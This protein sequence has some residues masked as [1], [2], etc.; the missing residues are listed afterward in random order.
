MDVPTLMLQMVADLARVR[1]DTQQMKSMYDDAM[2]YIENRANA[3][4]TALKG[5]FAGIVAAFSIAAIVG[6]I[7][8]VVSGTAALKQ[9]SEVTGATVEGLAN[10][11]SIAKLSDTDMGLVSGTLVKLAKGM[12]G[13]GDE[14]KGFGFALSKLGLSAKDANGQLKPTDQ[15]LLDI[16]LKFDKFADGPGKTAA[17]MALLGKQGAQLLPLLKDMADQAEIFGSK[18]DEERQRLKDL[19][20]QADEYEKNVKRLSVVKSA[21]WKQIVVESIPAMD[22]FVKALLSAKNESSGLKDKV[23]ELAKDGSLRNWAENV[24]LGVA[25]VVDQFDLF[26]RI[27]QTVGKAIGG[28][29]GVFQGLAEAIIAAGEGMS[30]NWIGASK[31]MASSFLLIKE[32]A[33]GAYKDIETVWSKATF[34]DRL[35]AQLDADRKAREA[36]AAKPQLGGFGDPEEAKKAS[37]AILKQMDLLKQAGALERAIIEAN[38]AVRKNILDGELYDYKAQ[39][40]ARELSER[41][42]IEKDTALRVLMAQENRARLQQELADATRVRDE[43]VKLQS[44]LAGKNAAETASLRAQ[45]MQKVIEQ[46]I[47][48]VKLTGDEKIATDAVTLARQKG[49]DALGLYYQRLADQIRA[50]TRATEDQARAAQD[51]TTAEQLQLSLIGATTVQQQTANTVYEYANKLRDNRIAQDR[52]IDDIE[53]KRINADVGNAQLV[54]LK[55]VNAELVTQRDN[56]L[57][58]IPLIDAQQKQVENLRSAW[59][60]IDSTAF[61]VFESMFNKGEDTW[62]KLA[63]SLKKTMIRALYELTVQKWA[64]QIFANISGS[65]GAGIV[66]GVQQGSGL[67]NTASSL[68][69]GAN[70]AYNWAGSAFPALSGGGSSSLGAG[71]GSFWGA[72]AEGASAAGALGGAAATGGGAASLGAGAGAFYGAGAEVGSAAASAAA[73]GAGAEAG[74][75]A[76][77]AAWVP[78][79]GWIVAIAALAYGIFASSKEPT[80]VRGGL[81]FGGPF[82]DNQSASQSAF[83]SFGFGDAQTQQFSGQVGKVMTDAIASLLDLAAKQLSPE[84]VASVTQTIHETVLKSFEGTFTTEDFIN[85]FG[86]QMAKQLLD[87]ALE[88]VDPYARELVDKFTGPFDQLLAYAGDILTVTGLLKDSSTQFTSLFGEAID[89]KALDGVRKEGESFGA[90]LGRVAQEFQLTNTIAVL[91]GKSQ[92]QVWGAVGLASESARA[93]LISFAGGADKLNASLGSYYDHYFSAE[94]KLQHQHDALADSFTGLGATMPSTLA[95]FRSLIEAQDLKTEAGRKEYAGL[96]ALEGQFY[97]YTTAANAAAGVTDDLAGS[98]GQL[99]DLMKTRSSLEIELMQ[100]QGNAA[101]ALAAQRKLDIA[102]M[103]A[104]EIAAYDYNKALEAQIATQN[105]TND[106]I[107]SGNGISIDLLRAEGLGQQA[108]AAER[109]I[110]I[111]GLTAEQIRL[112]DLNQTMRDQIA[113]L[114]LQK[115]ALKTRTDLEKQLFDLSHDDAAILANNRALKL[116]ELAAQEAAAHLAPG[117]LTNTQLQIDAQIDLNAAMKATSDA[118]AS[119]SSLWDQFAS[120]DMKLAKATQDVQDG[121]AKLGISVP[122]SSAAFADL[123]AGIDPATDAGKAMLEALKK[124]APAFTTITNAVHTFAEGIN[125]LTNTPYFLPDYSSQTAASAAKLEDD[126]LALLAQISE[127]TGDKALAQRVLDSQ[128]AIA[129]AAL[130]PSLRDLQTQLWGLQAAAAAAAKAAEFGKAKGDLAIQIARA[131]GNEQ[132]ALEL[133]RAQTIADINKQWGLGTDQASQ[134]IAMYQQLWSVQGQVV[135]SGSDWVKTLQDWL[136]GLHLDSS[137]SPLTARQ[138]FD[139]AQAQQM[140]DYLLAAVGDKDARSRYTQDSDALLREARA[141]YGLGSFQYQAIFRD[142]IDKANTLIAQGQAPIAPATITDLNSTTQNAASTAKQ[143]ADSMIAELQGLR[144]EVVD[145]RAETRRGNDNADANHEFAREDAEAQSREL[146]R[147]ITNAVASTSG[148]PFA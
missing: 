52:L 1:S 130:D 140:Q 44:Q 40:D 48:V 133:E 141:M 118:M 88:A 5:M 71:A 42:F 101:G 15:M 102:G 78:V 32:S 24:A 95:G 16:A 126:R 90:A 82:E 55:G 92:E 94:E 128:H 86:P 10:I 129:L 31:R 131:Q 65:S 68:Y 124:I 9:M 61:D 4:M 21:L 57:A 145:L 39:L 114:G 144:K 79:V 136:R 41:E 107:S 53:N 103:G 104:A 25:F 67:I 106:L 143:S 58:I 49:G 85:Q 108:N 35:R 147:T 100:A 72:G 120:S 93:Q 18:T 146:G 36:M 43:M 60:A 97:D 117:T 7:E 30:G 26:Y 119:Q 46:E 54:A 77:G 73:A 98:V 135:D 14:T 3:A 122:Q 81:A 12:A 34:G 64:L 142:Q 105:K 17:A 62:K 112:Y 8:K 63:D 89:L 11:R 96:L 70:T 127:L 138:R 115:E 2:K 111:Q 37:D 125:P 66:Q 23:N 134:L 38:A 69:S 76:A 148:A 19:A 56:H 6:F 87:P 45:G 22:S 121:F 139:A 28:G 27:F 13:A 113:L 33:L 83:G 59:Q 29:I 132:L 75:I 74:A 80:A 50:I 51:Q 137:L 99:A 84:A 91:M 110:A 123:V 47:K 116:A 109:A 20:E